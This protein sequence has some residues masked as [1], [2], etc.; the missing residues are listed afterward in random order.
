MFA[1]D[2][3]RRCMDAPGSA[4]E[5]QPRQRRRSATSALY[6]IAAS[7]VP[8]GLMLAVTNHIAANVGSVPFLWLVP[9]CGLSSDFHPRIRTTLSRRPLSGFR[10]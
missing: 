9:A 1:I 2:C 10:G 3:Q 6:W 4:G 7:F 8:S 5:E